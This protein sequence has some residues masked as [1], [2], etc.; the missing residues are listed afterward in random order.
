M[1]TGGGFTATGGGFTV[2]G[3]G[4]TVAGGG[5]TVT[6]DGCMVTGDGCMVTSNPGWSGRMDLAKASLRRHFSL[7]SSCRAFAR[8]NNRR[9]YRT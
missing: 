3:G 8:S 6:G 5:F 1:V 4:F 2:T 7:R 9:A